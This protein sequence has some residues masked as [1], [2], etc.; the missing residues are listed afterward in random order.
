MRIAI[1]DDDVLFLNK[2]LEYI[3][4]WENKPVDLVVQDFNNGDSLIDVHRKEPFD[5]IFMDV[6]M[7]MLN[8][9]DASMEI[10]AFDKNVKIVFLTTSKEFALDSYK[11]K[12]MNYLLK[13]IDDVK[14]YY[15]LNEFLEDYEKDS[16]MITIKA[17]YATFKIKLMD[18][19][20]VES[21]NKHVIIHCPDNRIY[22]TTTPLYTIEKELLNENYFFKIHRSYIINLY[23]VDSFTNKDITMH[24]HMIVP[25]SR[26]IKK[27]FEEKYFSVMFKEGDE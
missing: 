4:N 17:L 6:V 13:P 27:E 22:R 21:D 10:R 18:I 7:P 26:N 24:N 2:T 9:I 15:V 5:L 25:I 14:L 11:V 16:K 23:Y 20:Y 1:C 3:H 12:A 19:L 8:G